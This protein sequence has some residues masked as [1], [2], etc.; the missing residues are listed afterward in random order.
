MVR[1]NYVPEPNRRVLTFLPPIFPIE[2]TGGVAL[3]A[4]VVYNAVVGEGLIKL[5]VQAGVA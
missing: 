2:C 1:Q 4:S 5:E 3:I